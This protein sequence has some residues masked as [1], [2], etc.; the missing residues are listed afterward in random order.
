MTFKQ[1]KELFALYKDLEELERTND[2]YAFVALMVIVYSSFV[3]YP[4]LSFRI[5]ISQ[6][7]LD[8]LIKFSHILNQ[9][10][11]FSTYLTKVKILTL[12]NNYRSVFDFKK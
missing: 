6:N 8:N 3:N 11:F 9:I 4:V 5:I 7:N 1:I 2:L 12:V 10:K